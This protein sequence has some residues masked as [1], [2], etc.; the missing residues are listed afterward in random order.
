M[1]S[2]TM[3]SV[4]QPKDNKYV[5]DTKEPSNKIFTVAT[6]EQARA[7]NQAI[8][9]TNLRDLAAT[10]D[11]VPTL[12]HHSLISTIKLAD[13]N[14][15]TVFTPDEVLVY[16]EEVGPTKIPRDKVTGLWRVPLTDAVANTNTQTKLLLQY[17]MNQAFKERTLSVYT[18]PSKADVITYL[19]VAL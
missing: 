19:H 6:G 15:H 1:D 8:L 16:D 7:G 12:R 4:I 17:E 13:A 14:Y 11:M 3:S 5:I 9:R 18:L 2:G 10:A